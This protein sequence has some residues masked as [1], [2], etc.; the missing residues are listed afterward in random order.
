[1]NGYGPIL[2]SKIPI[3]HTLGQ[4]ILFIS[5]PQGDCLSINFK[6][7]EKVFTVSQDGVDPLL[8]TPTLR[9]GEFS[10]VS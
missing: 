9:K 8:W 3:N 7:Q 1:M 6:E 2:I 4:D 10:P 5:T